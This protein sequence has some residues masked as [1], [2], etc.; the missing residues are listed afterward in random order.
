MA[1]RPPPFTA[2][3]A[4]EC[5][6]MPRLFSGNPVGLDCSP[7]TSFHEVIPSPLRRRC[8]SVY[9]RPAEPVHRI[10]LSC[11]SL[12]VPVCIRACYAMSC[13]QDAARQLIRRGVRQN[14][15]R[16]ACQ[17]SRIHAR[18]WTGIGSF[19]KHSSAGENETDRLRPASCGP[20]S[21]DSGEGSVIRF[22]MDT[23]LASG[24]GQPSRT[25]YWR[26]LCGCFVPCQRYLI[27]LGRV[28]C[29]GR[30]R[31]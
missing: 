29:F 6:P 28:G 1:R 13:A 14:L 9:V 20:W 25:A 16:G 19:R 27:I 10:A 26:F 11:L 2:K 5:N 12:P 24:V 30:N 23:S 17:F 22:V 21:C 3:S 18:S 15:K 7:K 31:P 4:G 8:S